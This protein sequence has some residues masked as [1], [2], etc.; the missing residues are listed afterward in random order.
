[1]AF[2]LFHS[3]SFSGISL[4]VCALVASIA[5]YNSYLPVPLQGYKISHD[6][7]IALRA[8]Q[9]RKIKSRAVYYYYYWL[10]EFVD[11]MDIISGGGYGL[12]AIVHLCICFVQLS[13]ID[14]TQTVTLFLRI[15]I[16]QWSFGS[17]AAA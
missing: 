6:T 8:E 4:L 2:L 3:L 5:E 9:I 1:M 16:N 10:D 17:T 13:S 7:H 11:A 12:A 15:L 14:R